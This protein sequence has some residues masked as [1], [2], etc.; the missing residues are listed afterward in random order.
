[1]SDP[2]RALL[3]GPPLEQTLYPPGSRYHGIETAE[4]VE[5]DRTVRYLRR[6]FL[7]EP[8]GMTTL[9]E[10]RVEDGDR[11]D[12]L[13]ARYLG[14]PLQAWRI[15]DAH[16]VLRPEALVAEVGRRIRITVPF[17]AEGARN[18]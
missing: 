10:H 8:G 14:D 15:V 3:M 13:A 6:R 9:L 5:G 12:N 11:L 1:M 2:V 17:G 18:A 7:P 4:R 16:R